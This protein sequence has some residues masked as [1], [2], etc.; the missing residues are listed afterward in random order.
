MFLEHD[1]NL[2]EM[3]RLHQKIGT[4]DENLKLA[5]NEAKAKAEGEYI[6]NQ[7]VKTL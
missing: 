6:I 3:Q 4:L 2:A 7:L 5:A 1:M